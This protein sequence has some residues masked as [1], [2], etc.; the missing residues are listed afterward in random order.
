MFKKILF[1]LLW[2][3]LLI[4]AVDFAFSL[5]NM[6]N[7]IALIVGILLL[8]AVISLTYYLIKKFILK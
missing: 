3:I 6:P 8:F 2:I 1:G 7:T 5:M 4:L